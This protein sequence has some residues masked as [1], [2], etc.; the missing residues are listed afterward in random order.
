M[1]A[2]VQ[3]ISDEIR[4]GDATCFRPP[5]S[6]DELLRIIASIAGHD[7]ASRSEA[8]RQRKVLFG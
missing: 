4:D 6:S 2:V 1:V 7:I 5:S 3:E 8:T